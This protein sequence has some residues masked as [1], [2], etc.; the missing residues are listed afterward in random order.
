MVD[1]AIVGG[2]LAGGLIA[3]AL[4]RRRPELRLV[5]VERD[6]VLGANHRWSW[7]AGDLSVDGAALLDTFRQTRWDQGHD[8]AFPRLRRT[9]P[10]GYRSLASA[11]FHAGLV[12][13][14]P[15]SAIR[16]NCAVSRLDRAGITLADGERIPAR[17]VIDCRPFEPCGQLCGGW[18]VFMG[19]HLRLDQAHGVDRPVIMDATVAQLAPDGEGAAYR[20]VYVLPLGAHE[21]FVEDTYYTANARF[22][23]GLLSARIDRYCADRGWAGGRPLGHETGALPVITGGDFAAYQDSL[24][25]PGVAIAGARG[26]FAHPLTSYSLPFAVANALAIARESDLAGAHLAALCEARARRHW[27]RTGFYRMLGRMLFGAGKAEERYRVFER[28]YGLDQGLIERFYAGD[29]LLSDKARI[30][31]G[32]PP[33]PVLG[34]LAAVAAAGPPLNGET[35]R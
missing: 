21:L 9:L 19:R 4:M 28:F 16:L 3:L 23:R 27:R 14:L 11:D 10:A 20:F 32:R 35:A 12:R 8:V 34:A 7:F 5:L 17:A 2:G 15:H 26:G 33:V 29:T 22:D 1:V 13:L 6:A 31:A 18:Q 24:R 25:I 30:L